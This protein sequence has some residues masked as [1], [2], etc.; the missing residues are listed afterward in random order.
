MHLASSSPSSALPPGNANTLQPQPRRGECSASALTAALLDGARRQPE[1]GAFTHLAHDAALQVA[2]AGARALKALPI[3]VKDNID[4]AGMPTTAGSPALQDHVPA[5]SAS[6]VARLVEAGA[7][8][9]GKTS[10]HELALGVTSNNAAFGPVRNPYAPDRIAGGSSGGTAAAIAAGLAPAG[11]GTDTGGSVRIPAAL[12]GI[13][14]FRPSMG[15]WPADGVVPISAT[16]D[17]IGPMARTVAD[18]ALLDAVVCRE[19]PLLRVSLAGVRIGVPRPAFWDA[20]D[21]EVAAAGESCLARLARAGAVLVECDVGIKTAAC[22]EVGLVIAMVENLPGL[23]RYFAAH[24]L[25]FDPQRFAAAVASP[26]VRAVLSQLLGPDAPTAEAHAHALRVQ[27]TAYRRAYAM[28]FEHHRIEALIFPTTPLPAARI[29]EDETVVLQGRTVSTFRAYTRNTV[30]ASVVGL[31]AISLPM[32]LSAAGLPMGIE[33]DGP[34]GSD[35]RLLALA[36]GLEALLPA[37]PAP[38]TGA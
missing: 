9:L 2:R 14:G 31:P 22:A 12:C 15:R 23:R 34:E 11:L 6:A 28:C 26:D 8:I 21:P 4:V 32:G 1:L 35:R 20:L 7:V 16:C 37:T 27:R 38:R 10:L 30:P 25:P 3:V 17:T 18:C 36:A 33:L 5:R 29:G 13:V 24:G 19:A